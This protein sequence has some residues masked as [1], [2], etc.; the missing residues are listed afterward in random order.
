MK[1]NGEKGKALMREPRKME[2]KSPKDKELQARDW[3]RKFSTAEPRLSEAKAEYE[4]LGFEVLIEPVDC[5]PDNPECTACLAENPG[6]VKVI[7]TRPKED[8]P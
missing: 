3:R 5:N 1:S 7:Y 8:L 4:E 6:Q 2:L